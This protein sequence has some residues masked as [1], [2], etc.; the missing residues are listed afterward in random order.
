MTRQE[1][2]QLIAGIGL[3]YAY[4]HFEAEESPGTPPFICFLYPDSGGLFADNTNYQPIERLVIELYT[5]A[6]DFE[7]EASVLAALNSAGLACTYSR[8]WIEDER[9]Y[10]TT[11]DTE[12]LINAPD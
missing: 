5:D 12:V 4:D 11:F 10:L 7:L 6:V 8:E 1:I 3:P 9:M 2:A